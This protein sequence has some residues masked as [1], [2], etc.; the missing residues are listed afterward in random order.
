M[1]SQQHLHP[2]VILQLRS[3]PFHALDQE[4]MSSHMAWSLE[5][6]HG[7]KNRF[8]PRKTGNPQSPTVGYQCPEQ[9]SWRDSPTRNLWL[10]TFPKKCPQRQPRFFSQAQLISQSQTVDWKIRKRWT[11]ET[12]DSTFQCKWFVLFLHCVSCSNSVYSCIYVYSLF[13]L[14]FTH[15]SWEH[16]FFL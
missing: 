12:G 6:P 11:G 1:F 14:F 5:L 10:S 15:K 16:Y 4:S 13:V 3:W 8:K 7:V 9:R 2:R